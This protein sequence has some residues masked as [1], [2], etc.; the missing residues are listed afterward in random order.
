MKQFKETLQDMQKRL[1]TYLNDRLENAPGLSN[2]S[3]AVNA[4]D[5][6]EADNAASNVAIICLLEKSSNVLIDNINAPGVLSQFKSFVKDAKAQYIA[7]TFADD[8]D[9]DTLFA[10]F[11]GLSD[12]ELKYV[13]ADY[14]DS[15]KEEVQTEQVKEEVQTEQVKE[16]V[17]TEQVKEEVQTE[18]VEEVKVEAAKPARKRKSSAK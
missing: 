8:I 9:T 18:Q 15:V 4:I 10:E 17:Q 1:F 11:S 12:D 5:S 13:I 6:V 2:I 7:S 14:A 3:F 16:E